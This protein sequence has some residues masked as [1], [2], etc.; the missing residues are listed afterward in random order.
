MSLLVHLPK[1]EGPLALLLYLIRKEEMDIMDINIHEITGQYLEYVRQMRELDLE[2]AGEFVAMAATLIQIKSRMLLPQ[3]NEQGEIVESEDPRKELVQ[4]LLEYQKF[5]EGARLLNERAWVGRDLLLRGL[6]EDL[7]TAPEE[8][9]LEENAL[10]S[11][12]TSYR[13]VLKTAK[14]KVHEVGLKLQSIASRILEMRERLVPGHSIGM[15]ELYKANDLRSRQ[16]L[17]TF[18]SVLE[19]AKM[20][21][22][23]LFQSDVYSEIWI[24]TKRAITQDVIGKVEEYDAAAATITAET[25]MATPSTEESTAAQN[26]ASLSLEEPAMGAVELSDLDLLKASDETVAD[27]FDIY[28]Q[29]NLSDEGE[30]EGADGPLAEK[31]DAD[32]AV[33]EIASDDEIFQAEIEL[34]LRKGPENSESVDELIRTLGLNLDFMETESEVVIES[35]HHA[36][37]ESKN[38][39]EP[40]I[41]A[42][43]PPASEDQNPEGDANV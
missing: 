13:N 12:I 27:A 10:F 43:E 42:E 3:Y 2:M 26:L 15:S 22:V 17:I 18:L 32:L 8:I 40:D 34:G 38:E 29:E 33:E 7:Q 35:V 25:L 6:R 4:R 37:N 21:Y 20:G 24:E 31:S 39:P 1:F 9:E 23:F 19:L 28:G 5:Q 36:V 16:I 11:L 14:K 41:L 30:V